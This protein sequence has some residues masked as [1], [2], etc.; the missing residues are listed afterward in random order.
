M[1]DFIFDEFK[2]GVLSQIHDAER[3]ILIW[4]HIA[5]EKEFLETQLEDVQQ[6]YSF[7]QL[8]AQTNFVLSVGKLFDKPKNYPTQCILYFLTL[9]EKRADKNLEIV[10]D[11]STKMLLARYN[12][13]HFLIKAVN[14]EDWSQFPKHFVTYYREKYN[15]QQVQDD[16][17]QVKLMRDKVVAHNEATESIKL[18]F[19]LVQRLLKFA[20]EVVS[21]FGMPYHS[22]IWETGK[23][24][25]ITENAKRNAWFVKSGIQKLKK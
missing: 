1:T 11:S 2:Q 19:E 7:L 9:V 6:L 21:V 10:E 3:N 12:A 20:T 23:I 22:T 13:S 17:K 16:I 18:E 24:S 5:D 15:S 25:M 4:Q 14:S 8:A